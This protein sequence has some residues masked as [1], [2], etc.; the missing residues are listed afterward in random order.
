M[1]EKE[2]CRGLSLRRSSDG[3][4]LCFS[5]KEGKYASINLENV[6]E[7]RRI[8]SDAILGWTDEQFEDTLADTEDTGEKCPKC[9]GEGV[10][11]SWE[12]GPN[13]TKVREYTCDNCNGTGHLPPKEQDDK[14]IK[15]CAW[16]VDRDDMYG[17]GLW[18]S[19]CGV[20]YQFSNGGPVDNHHKFC[21]GCGLPIQIKEEENDS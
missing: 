8:I 13:P 1:T 7:G 12:P 20:S 6:F 14:P 5:T 15:H 19:E 21:H 16:K 2:I 17:S 4:W 3:N 9:L 18:E 10:Y 11:E